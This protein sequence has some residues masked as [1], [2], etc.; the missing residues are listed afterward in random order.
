MV[1]KKVKDAL[2]NKIEELLEICQLNGVPM[3]V[4]VALSDDGEKT[5]YYNQMF[6][7]AAHDIHLTDDQ[8]AGHI[9]ISNGFKAVP[10]RDYIELNMGEILNTEN[11]EA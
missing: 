6:S 7:A 1:T 9:L 4:T 2:T 3:F 11:E 8:I 5:E 10:K